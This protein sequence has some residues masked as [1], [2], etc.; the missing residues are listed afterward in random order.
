MTV[1]ELVKSPAPSRAS[2]IIFYEVG[3]FSTYMSFRMKLISVAQ[4][5]IA[6]SSASAVERGKI[7]AKELRQLNT[8]LFMEIM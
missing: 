2:I 7:E 6:M 1:P 3:W 4:A 8:A 5:M